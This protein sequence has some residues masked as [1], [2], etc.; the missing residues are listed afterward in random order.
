M[1]ITKEES[2]EKKNL[3]LQQTNPINHSTSNLNK[4]DFYSFLQ[5]LN[6]KTE[7]GIE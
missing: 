7:L 2:L 5:E 3:N 6:Y 1:G 4:M